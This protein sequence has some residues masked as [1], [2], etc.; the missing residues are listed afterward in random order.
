M[1]S[2]ELDNITVIILADN[3]TATSVVNKGACVFDK[4]VDEAAKLLR[5]NATKRGV[6][7]QH[8]FRGAN[9]QPM[10]FQEGNQLVRLSALEPSNMYSPALARS[11]SHYTLRVISSR[12]GLKNEL[13]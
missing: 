7:L 9:N 11:L 3:I 2:S 4:A 12:R 5:R 8:A 13:P 6:I 1:D 10:S